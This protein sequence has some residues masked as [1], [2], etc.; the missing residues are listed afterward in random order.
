MPRY[1]LARKLLETARSDLPEGED[2]LDRA[3]LSK[4]IRRLIE[5]V[6]RMLP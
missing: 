4:D 1:D 2:P 3:D 5:Q 6:E